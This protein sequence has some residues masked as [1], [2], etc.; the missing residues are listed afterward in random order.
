MSRVDALVDVI[1]SPGIEAFGTDKEGS[2]VGREMK[3]LHVET[4]T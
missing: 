2:S 4:N 3:I 1:R